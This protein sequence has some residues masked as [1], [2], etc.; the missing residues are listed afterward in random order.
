MRKSLE[1]GH[2][3]R[4]LGHLSVAF[5]LRP[6]CFRAT[7]Y[8]R[9]APAILRTIA[10]ERPPRQMLSVSNSHSKA[11]VLTPKAQL[12]QRNQNARLRLNSAHACLKREIARAETRRNCQIY[13]IQAGPGQPRE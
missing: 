5:L 7:A 8:P 13:L 6:V 12:L 1:V 11:V 9:R 4:F 3:K 2:F 10:P